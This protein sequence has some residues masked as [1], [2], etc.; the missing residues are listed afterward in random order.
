MTEP[1]PLHEHLANGRMHAYSELTVQSVMLDPKSSQ[2]RKLA[3]Q[4]HDARLQRLGIRLVVTPDS[5][6]AS[7]PLHLYHFPV[8]RQWAREL[9]RDEHT[10]P[11]GHEQHAAPGFFSL[12][13]TK[14][15]HS[16]LQQVNV[17]LESQ[18]EDAPHERVSFYV[19]HSTPDGRD[20][21]A[22]PLGDAT[23]QNEQV[24]FTFNHSEGT[25][26]L[27]HA[28]LQHLFQPDFLSP[29]AQDA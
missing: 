16:A 17:L 11:S 28:L 26:H 10:N 27:I 19:Y 18:G 8:L 14:G 6:L 5:T 21:Q 3:I 2:F 12:P 4:S 22:V 29:R 20:V 23:V 25:H 7:A 9:P 24:Q 13:V 1:V 15:H